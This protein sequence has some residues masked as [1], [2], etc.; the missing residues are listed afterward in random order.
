MLAIGKVPYFQDLF[1]RSPTI[2]QSQFPPKRTK[3]GLV[4]HL[5]C[6][7]YC[8]YLPEVGRLVRYLTTILP[9][10][11]PTIRNALTSPS[12]LPSSSAIPVPSF[13]HRTLPEAADRPELTYRESLKG[14]EDNGPFQTALMGAPAQKRAKHWH[15][16]AP[17]PSSLSSDPLPA[18]Y[19]QQTQSQAYRQLLQR[20]TCGW[21]PSFVDAGPPSL[22]SHDLVDSLPPP[23][24]ATSVHDAPLPVAAGDQLP[25]SD[26]YLP[27]VVD[28]WSQD[29]PWAG[30]LCEDD[31]FPSASSFPAQR[32]SFL[33]SVPSAPP[34]AYAN[35]FAASSLLVQGRL[36]SPTTNNGKP[37]G[38]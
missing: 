34:D 32:F 18:G 3:F 36:P 8:T 25:I 20:T 24:I 11:T 33:P 27:I 7:A 23:L 10:P 15:D 9:T 16:P 12:T 5:R 30:R 17:T 38:Y 37:F 31:S 26:E 1:Q 22:S 13:P 35:V 28:N 14:P 6:R 29:A 21:V 2:A 4:T 19:S